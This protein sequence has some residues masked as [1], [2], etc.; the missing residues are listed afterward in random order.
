MFE[1][2]VVPSTSNYGFIARFQRKSLCKEKRCFIIKTETNIYQ[3]LNTRNLM[4]N[5]LCNNFK[6]S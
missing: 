3:S 6:G 1:L 2:L 4:R 5:I